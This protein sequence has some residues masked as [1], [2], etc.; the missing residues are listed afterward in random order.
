[1]EKNGCFL[2][3][4]YSFYSFVRVCVCVMRLLIRSDSLVTSVTRAGP[5]KQSQP[6][7][8]GGAAEDIAGVGVT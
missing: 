2:F 8:A 4:S 5:V 3:F 1:M 6:T 7:V